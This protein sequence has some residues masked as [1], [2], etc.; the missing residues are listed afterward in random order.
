M[1]AAKPAVAPNADGELRHLEVVDEG[2][3]A[4]GEQQ[5]VHE[6]RRSSAYFHGTPPV[7][8]HL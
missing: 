7:G 1:M 6:R 2:T 3:V 8:S 5:R 4:G